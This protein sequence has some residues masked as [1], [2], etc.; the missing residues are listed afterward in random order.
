MENVCVVE[1]RIL[2][3][4]LLEPCPLSQ[5]LYLLEIPGLPGK[6]FTEFS[7]VEKHEQMCVL[8]L[9]HPNTKKRVGVNVNLDL[10]CL[11][12]YVCFILHAVK[13]IKSFFSVHSE[14]LCSILLIVSSVTG[15]SSLCLRAVCLVLDL[16]HLLL[17]VLQLEKIC[18]FTPL[19]MS[20]NSGLKPGMIAIN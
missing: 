13:H 12:V 17:Q 15:S 18:F 5:I 16:G 6:I 14:H 3:S 11:R 19:R 8:P 4:Q 10:M 7:F 2:L 20:Y 9:N 1:F